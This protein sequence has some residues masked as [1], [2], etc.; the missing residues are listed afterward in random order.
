MLVCFIYTSFLSKTQ[1][2]IVFFLA[3]LHLFLFNNFIRTLV[4]YP[5]IHH[6]LG[7][8]Y[9]QR[10]QQKKQPKLNLISHI[11]RILMHKA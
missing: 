11:C 10:V 8:S 6:F 3:E 4:Q 1:K 5:Y 2:E 7:C 9:G